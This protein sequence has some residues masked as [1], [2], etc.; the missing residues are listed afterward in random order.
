MSDIPVL[1]KRRLQADVIQPIYQELVSELGEERAQQIL[2]SA[3]RKPTLASSLIQLIH[4]IKYFT[5][6]RL[7]NV[8]GVSI[9]P[10]LFKG[11]L[12]TA[13][14]SVLASQVAM[15]TEII[16]DGEYNFVKAQYGDAWDKEDKEINALARPWRAS[17]SSGC[18]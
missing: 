15:A 13:L 12:G 7:D 4:L 8:F 3:I 11:L 16:H 1:T 9:M 5:A 14:F 10:S 2:D 17:S 18:V 6:L